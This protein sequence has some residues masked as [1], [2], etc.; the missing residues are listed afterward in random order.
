[1]RTHAVK[2]GDRYILNG[3]KTWISGVPTADVGLVFA[4]TN[5]EAKHRG[6]SCFIVDMKNTKGVT[7]TEITTK[8]GL[9]CAPTGEISFEDA[10]VPEENLLGERKEKVLRYA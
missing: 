10:E 1:M 2:K 5:R 8:L 9:F 4:Y 7:M 3:Q 6:I